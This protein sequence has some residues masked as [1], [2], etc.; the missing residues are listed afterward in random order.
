MDL[1]RTPAEIRQTRD[2]LVAEARESIDYSKR[3]L[4]SYKRGEWNPTPD[5]IQRHKRII[6]NMQSKVRRLQAK[7]DELLRIMEPTERDE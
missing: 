2:T 1:T 7:A 5:R 4:E 3:M 6:S